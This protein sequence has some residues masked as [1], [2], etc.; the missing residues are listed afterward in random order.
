[1]RGDALISEQV[2]LGRS[3]MVQLAH[4]PLANITEH[5]ITI[6][7]GLPLPY[8][9]AVSGLGG[10]AAGAAGVAGAAVVGREVG[11]STASIC[12]ATFLPLF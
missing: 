3:L 5:A 8:A 10:W 12:S 2:G 6:S 4:F 9:L 1:M 11:F 7:H